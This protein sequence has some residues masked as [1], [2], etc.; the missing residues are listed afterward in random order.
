[1]SNKNPVN[2][3]L[4][5]IPSPGDMHRKIM[6]LAEEGLR[7]EEVDAEIERK[8]LEEKKYRDQTIDLLTG[9]EKNTAVFHEISLLM[10]KNT[11]KQEETFEIIIE[12]LEML[13]TSNMEENESKYRK[14]MKKINQFTGDI[15]SFQTLQSLC[16]TI[17]NVVSKL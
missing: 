7:L 4:K 3:T 10:R 11:D 9:I 13:K 1:M 12:M 6:D 8:S 14:V 17:F 15:Q 5:S 2:L 16:N